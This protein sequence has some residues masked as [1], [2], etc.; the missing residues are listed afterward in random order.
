MLEMMG[1]FMVNNTN[2]LQGIACPKCKSQGP[3]KIDC[4]ILMRVTDDGTEEMGGDTDWDDDS[5]CECFA[6]GHHARV[7]DFKIDNKRAR[8][9]YTVLLNYPND[10]TDPETYLAHVYAD[11]A[12]NAVERA[13]S[14]AVI[15]N[16]AEYSYHNNEFTPILVFE[17]HH[18][19][20]K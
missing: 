6:C 4:H 15:A 17:G 8:K 12:E 20:A 16:N 9:S 18:H 19:N 10:D 1:K 7:S 3:F 5:Y 13:R 14:Q 2:C 11:S